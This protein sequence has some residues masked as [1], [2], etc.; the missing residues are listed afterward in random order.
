MP[1]PW[2]PVRIDVDELP[3]EH[4]SEALELLAVITLSELARIPVRGTVS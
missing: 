2:E 1:E 3:P 4:Q